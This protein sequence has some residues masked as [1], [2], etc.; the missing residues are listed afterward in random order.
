MQTE[1]IQPIQDLL[2]HWVLMAQALVGSIGVLA[3]TLAFIW[4]MTAVSSHAVIQSRQWLLRIVV[5]VIGVEMAG[6]L[7][8]VLTSSVT[9]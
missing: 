9:H 2:Q 1:A 7:V 6:V 8:Q 4:R 5:G 3:T